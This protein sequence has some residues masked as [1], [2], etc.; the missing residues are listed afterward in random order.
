VGRPT[1]VRS[2]EPRVERR[3]HARKGRVPAL[4]GASQH[5]V[6][7]LPGRCDRYAPPPQTLL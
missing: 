2:R 7:G 5:H 6:Q 4:S 3:S 1:L